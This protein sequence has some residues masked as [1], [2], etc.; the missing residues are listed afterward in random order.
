[1]KALVLFSGGLDSILAVR[2][3]QKQNIEVT[4]ITFSSYFFDTLQARK[5]SENLGIKLIE[6]DIAQ[7]QLSIVKKPR[8]GRGGGLNPCI[9]CHALMIRTAYAI[10]KQQ[11]I[12]ILAT[13]E[14]LGQRPFSQNGRA[15]KTIEQIYNLQDKI[16][17]PLSAQLLE[18]TDYEKKGWVNRELLEKIQGRSRHRQMELAKDLGVEYYPTPAGGC[19]LTEKEF[20]KKLA[21]LMGNIENPTPEDFELIRLGRHFWQN[22]FNEGTGTKLSNN[23]H[24]ILG[25]SLEEN[26]KIEGLVS[27]NDL[28]L[29][30]KDEKGPTALLRDYHI[31]E[32]AIKNAALEAAKIKIWE[33]SKKKPKNH[34]E[35]DFI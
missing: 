15:L 35:L 30:R 9:D 13:G 1:M 23:F 21:N 6:T 12:D 22:D 17:R 31:Q 28:L 20:S 2:L 19:R 8:H 32:P 33:F 16:L 25:R 4:A 34:A 26:Q 14:V 11:G 7:E 27:G 24:I 18:E 29:K 10:M 3:L 5:S